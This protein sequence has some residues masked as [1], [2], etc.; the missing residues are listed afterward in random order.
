MREGLLHFLLGCMKQNFW[1]Q[2]AT[3]MPSAC[4]LPLALAAL[5]TRARLVDGSGCGSAGCSWRSAYACPWSTSPGS[6][7]YADP[8]L[9][10][11]GCFDE[12]CG[13][14]SRPPVPPPSPS[15]APT[16]PPPLPPP[17]PP[18]SPPLP[19]PLPPM[20]HPPPSPPPPP[21]TPPS[22][23]PPPL[24]PPPPLPPSPPPSPPKHPWLGK[25][26]SKAMCEAWRRKDTCPEGATA[27]GGGCWRLGAVGQTC[28]QV[29]GADAMVDIQGTT[30]VRLRVRVRVRFG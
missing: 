9:I 4:P 23:P 2:L 19:S 15:P 28:G 18:P 26:V 30:D 21:P 12:C 27:I 16:P 25:G 5:L 13:G 14:T 10:G 20:P 29:C 24:L 17:S 8:W 22:P 1:V 3:P 6:L 11:A 7:G